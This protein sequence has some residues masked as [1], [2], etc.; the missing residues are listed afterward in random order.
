MPEVNALAVIVGLVLIAIGPGSGVWVAMKSSI[1]VLRKD[2]ERTAELLA[3]INQHL[4]TL[5]SRVSKSEDHIEGL[6]RREDT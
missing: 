1:K 6:E 3:Q 4:A 5:N 2:N